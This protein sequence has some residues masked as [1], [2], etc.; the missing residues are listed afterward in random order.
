MKLF[1]YLII[2]VKVA[3]I[4]LAIAL[5]Y[6]KAKGKT[7]DPKAQHIQFWKD[8]MEFVFIFLMSMLILSLFYP[9]RP[10]QHLNYETRLLLFLFGIILL[11]TADWNTFFHESP[12]LQH[13]QSVLSTS[14]RF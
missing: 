12:A 4:G 5:L 10:Q 3:F 9:R 13:I 2:A 1:I 11:I 14:K 6:Y 8:R 7:S